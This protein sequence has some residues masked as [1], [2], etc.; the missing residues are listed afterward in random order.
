MK[1]P[2][3][4]RE[5][6]LTDEERKKIKSVIRNEKVSRTIRCR[7]Q[8]LNLVDSRKDLTQIQISK[9]LGIAVS[10]VNLAIKKYFEEGIDSVL[11]YAYKS[12]SH[13]WRVKAD[14]RMEAIVVA[15]ACSPPPDGMSRWTHKA[16]ANAL[17]KEM[18]DPPCASTVG[19]ILRRNHMQ[20][21]RSRYW[22]SA[23]D[24]EKEPD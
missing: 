20:P 21:H 13:E 17:A 3:Q 2:N 1:R 9:Q 11:K 23:P 24:P 10:T 19:K 14:G 4:K 8:V 18:D 16:L 6:K 22:C 7:A 12:S 15:K 5:V